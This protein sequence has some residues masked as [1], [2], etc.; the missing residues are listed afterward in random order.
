MTTPA[1][2]LAK[3]AAGA[4]PAA[5]RRRNRPNGSGDVRRRRRLPD[6]DG[7]RRI[8][9]DEPRRPAE[10]ERC[11]GAEGGADERENGDAH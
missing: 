11:G 8:P 5:P 9:A 7:L 10:T 3:I 6:D 1:E 4:K 2:R